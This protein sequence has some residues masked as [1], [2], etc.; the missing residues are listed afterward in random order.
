LIGNRSTL[1][2]PRAIPWFVAAAALVT[3][4][5]FG[6]ELVLRHESSQG[7][8][9]AND[10]EVYR[11][12]SHLL[13]QGD[14]ATIFDP[15]KFFAAHEATLQTAVG[16]SPFPYPPSAL[17][18]VA[19][20]ELLPGILGPLLWLGLPFAALAWLVARQATR[21]WHAA[22]ALLLAPAALDNI[23]TGQNGFLSGALLCGGLLLLQSRPI[24]AGL[25]I[26]LLSF[27][28]QFGILLPFILL[29]GG[30][31]RTF[32]TAAAVTVGLVLISLLM[33][34]TEPWRIYFETAMPS[35]RGFLENGGGFAILTMPSVF[36]AGRLLGLPTIINYVLQGIAAL[37]TIAACIWLFSRRST[38]LSLKAPVA[39]VG[40]FLVTPYCSGYDLVI[41]AAAQIL[42]LTRAGL[43]PPVQVQVHAAAWLLPL[44]MITL[45]LFHMPIGP[46]VLGILFW[47]LLRRAM[48][49]V[50]AAPLQP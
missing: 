15:Q 14:I 21:P 3:I 28:P 38:D 44:L 42:V 16:F 27:K 31:Y 20:L 29:A 47:L 19:P 11:F 9:L 10:Y 24:V 18:V 35:Q 5:F 32:I 25:L 50:G 13:W 34:G 30:Y 45:S 48:A 43:V 12:A 6:N 8:V 22:A 7:Q 2:N 17:W 4:L 23:A 41:V 1:S 49:G 40:I 37:A 33:F 46:L 36:N 39:M 26:G